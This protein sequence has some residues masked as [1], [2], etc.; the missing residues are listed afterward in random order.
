MS[1]WTNQERDSAGTLA[2]HLSAFGPLELPPGWTA[3]PQ[4][5]RAWS[6]FCGGEYV[7]ELGRSL[8]GQ[9]RLC[10]AGESL[11]LPRA[12]DTRRL[13]LLL[14]SASRRVSPAGPLPASIG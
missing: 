2:D 14:C 7:A 6:L 8:V 9:W 3:S 5:S 11:P 1:A 4:T 13:P 12:Y 10:L